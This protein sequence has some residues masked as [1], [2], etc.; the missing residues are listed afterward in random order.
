ML[1]DIKKKKKRHAIV[2]WLIVH[3]CKLIT[4]E[5]YIVCNFN[6]T[7]V[8]HDWFI[9]YTGRPQNTLYENND[10]FVLLH[11]NIVIRLFYYVKFV[12]DEGLYFE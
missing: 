12:L 7:S 1:L 8:E 9:N 5:E 10:W 3:L 6:P 11:Q 4:L 2:K